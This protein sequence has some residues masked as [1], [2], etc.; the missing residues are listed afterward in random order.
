[1]WHLLVFLAFCMNKITLKQMTKYKNIKKF[2]DLPKFIRDG[3]INTYS[4]WSYHQKMNE[5]YK[6]NNPKACDSVFLSNYIVY[7]L[8][9]IKLR[10]NII[11]WHVLPSLYAPFHVVFYWMSHILS[12]PTAYQERIMEDIKDCGYQNIRQMEGVQY[13]HL[14]NHC[15]PMYVSMY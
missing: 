11:S 5:K 2:A 10:N 9:R 13:S 6:E 15:V 1:M 3:E 4:Y 8:C 12:I 7:W 14:N